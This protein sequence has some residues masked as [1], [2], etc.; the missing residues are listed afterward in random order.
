MKVVF[1]GGGTGGHFYPLIAVAESLQ[2]LIAK[3][4]RV[5]PEMFY[6]APS[7]YDEKALYE[8]GLEYRHCPA[9]KLPRAGVFAFFHKI[10]ALIFLPF[11]LL[12]AV[13][14]MYRIYP[15]VVFS[16]GAY[17]AFPVVWAA[18]F[19]RIPIIIHESDA[20]FGKVNLWSKKIA[21]QIAISFPE[22]E[23]FLSAREKKYTAL[24]GNPIRRDIMKNPYLQA[25]ELLKLKEDIPTVLVLGGSLG[26]EYLNETVLDVLPKLLEKYQV[27]H[28][29]GKNNFK[30]TNDV[31][32]QILSG[33]PNARRYYSA[34]F[35]SNHYLRAAYSIADIAI[36]RAGSGVLHELAE[37]TIPSIV[38]PIPK[39]IS[40]DQKENA[41]A[42]ARATGVAVIEQRNA[43]P[44]IVFSQVEKIFADKGYRN[45]IQ[46]KL[47]SFSQ[48]DASKRLARA[49][50]DIL[51]EHE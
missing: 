27:I 46:Q 28:Q 23:R 50:L 24:V 51:I 16:K 10:K 39:E 18:K 7:P 21:R 25:K 31:V 45:I 14:V 15:D 44:N 36:S 47:E 29:T 22:T 42:Y 35:L 20:V 48:K 6:V 11:T 26:S 34:P 33:N 4:H 43:S 3:E 1:A 41:Y 32:R 37:W 40:H 19:L 17:P 49:I 12:I 38:I 30:T 9:N 5:R 2:D 13:F 8:A